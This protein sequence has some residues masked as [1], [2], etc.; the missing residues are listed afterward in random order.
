[1]MAHNWW[2]GGTALLGTTLLLTNRI[3]P[4]MFLLLSSEPVTGS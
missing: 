2:I 4:A 3:D 1:M